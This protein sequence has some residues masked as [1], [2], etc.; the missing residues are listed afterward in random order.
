MGFIKPAHQEVMKISK[1]YESFDEEKIKKIVKE[2]IRKGRIFTVGLDRALYQYIQRAATKLS[3]MNIEP[4]DLG[5]AHILKN[6]DYLKVVDK[7]WELI[8]SGILS[9]GKDWE[10]SW[11]P[12]LHL[13][14]KGKDFMEE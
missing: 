11:F 14:E 5:R 1:K 2:L 9:P 10:N 13:T 12:N 6:D 7:I 8:T 3:Y 4:M